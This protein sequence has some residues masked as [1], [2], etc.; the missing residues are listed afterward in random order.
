M[1]FRIPR[2]RVTDKA[3][4]DV[5]ELK[6]S[7]QV[8]MAES[9]FSQTTVEASPGGSFC[10][11]SAGV[12]AGYSESASS[13]SAAS[14]PR[15]EIYLDQE[16]LKVSAE[17]KADLDILR[18]KR[19]R[20]VFVP[21]VQ[22]GGRLYSIKS[23]QSFGLASKKQ[24]SSMMKASTSASFAG[25]GAKA[26]STILVSNCRR[27][28]ELVFVAFKVRSTRWGESGRK[29]ADKAVY[30]Y[31]TAY[32]RFPIL[33][34]H[35][36]NEQLLCVLQAAAKKSDVAWEGGIAR[37]KYGV[38]YRPYIYDKGDFYGIRQTTKDDYFGREGVLYAGKNEH[39]N[40]T[41]KVCS[42][43]GQEIHTDTVGTNHNVKL[44][45]YSANDEM[46]KD[47]KDEDDIICLSGEHQHPMEFV[48]CCI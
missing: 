11:A 18:S 15:V 29:L 8:S 34:Y 19:T 43:C 30:H 23:S 13:S 45:F 2:F 12:K 37:M 1:E 48:L 39:S 21:Q 10:G 28:S 9:A 42:L 3:H 24:K 32:E 38:S 26:D 40:V 27:L 7:L 6:S 33:N 44:A 4:V 17:C 5:L 31:P 35:E 47:I 16:S 22:P 25:F 46:L 41:F 14:F 20:H 36:S